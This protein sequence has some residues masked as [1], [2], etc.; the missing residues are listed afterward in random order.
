MLRRLVLGFLAS[1]LSDGISLV[2]LPLVVYDTTA[3]GLLTGVAFALVN[4]LQLLGRPVGGLLADRTDRHR[5]LRVSLVLRTLLLAVAAVTGAD[6]VIVVCL[7]LV[8]AGSAIDNPAAEA[9]IRERAGD[10]VQQ[11][12]TIRQL[13]RAMSGL[14]G[15]GAGGLLVGLV[16]VRVAVGVATVGFVVAL[17]VLPRAPARS[18]TARAPADRP[19][20]EP[21]R[22]VRELVGTALKEWLADAREGL[23][24]LGTHLDLRLGPASMALNAG[25]VSALLTVAV[26]YLARLRGAPAGAYGYALSGYSAGSIAGLLVA[27]VIAWRL[28]LSTVVWRSLLVYGALCLLGVAWPVWWL[29]AVSWL[30]WGMANGPEAVVSDSRLVTLTPTRLLGRTYAAVG[31]VVGLAQVVGGLVGGVVVEV[32][33]P[34][35]VA[36]GLSA[37]FLVMALPFWWWGRSA[38]GRAR[39]PAAADPS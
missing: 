30:L 32:A 36:A 12:A 39:Q 9:A 13:S 28:A 2:L 34:R 11:V 20:R 16:G 35:T 21:D 31:M 18:H 4:G 1:E 22:P 23:A 7:V 29:L 25:L 10:A 37:C 26:V 5:I 8:N 15:L 6:P 27:G 19:S 33:S 17:A 24:H 3:S 14:V 38:D